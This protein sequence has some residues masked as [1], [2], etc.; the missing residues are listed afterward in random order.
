MRTI[1]RAGIAGAIASAVVLAG[2]I[3]P[4]QAATPGWRQVES[5]HFGPAKGYS[6]YET[7][8]AFGK[9][10][11]WAFGGSDLGGGT[12]TPGVPVAVHWNGHVWAAATMPA[13][14]TGAIG[15]VSA[16]AAN[17]IWAITQYGGWILHYNGKSWTVAKH[18]PSTSGGMDLQ[19]TGIQAFST[20][21]VWV[22]GGGGEG[23][24]MGTWHY[25]GHTW[26]HETTAATGLGISFASAVSASNIWASGSDGNAPEDQLEHFNGHTWT[27]VHNSAL[28]NLQFN[29]IAALSA[30]NIWGIAP[31]ESGSSTKTYLLHY[32]NHWSKVALPSGLVI[33]SSV[34]SDGHGGLWMT[35]ATDTST[36]PHWYALH[37][38]PG[39]KWTKYAING[40]VGG[41]TPVL[42]PG[43]T[44]AVLG[45]FVTAKTGGSAVVWAYGSI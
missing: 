16:P 10:N 4:A 23:P 1:K 25:D 41:F 36:T 35:A 19:F 24:G 14:V 18:L 27:A 3:L 29:G 22:F 8:A 9:N 44:S 12:G 33:G 32:S 2:T 43:T 7:E 15:A 20:S 42:I 11:I 40:W 13:G 17:D 28:T 5:H 6:G 26:R 21:N 39:N 45:G 37:S 38:A 31:L 34:S 30:A